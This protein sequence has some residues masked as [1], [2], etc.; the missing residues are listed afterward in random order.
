MSSFGIVELSADSANSSGQWHMLGLTLSWGKLATAR[1][2]SHQLELLK[3]EF[4][5]LV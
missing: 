3:C 1:L 5:Y 2:L 4:P